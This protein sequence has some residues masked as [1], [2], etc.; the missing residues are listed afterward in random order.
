MT[1]L[2]K[3][4][5]EKHLKLA[6]CVAEK[7]KVTKE[8]KAKMIT[9]QNILFNSNET[10]LM[11][12]PEFLNDCAKKFLIKHL[13]VID[14]L[15]TN[16]KITKTPHLFFGSY[17][18]LMEHLDALIGIEKYYTMKKPLP[19]KF[20][21]DVI[22][23]KSIY[24]DNMIKRYWHEVKTK[25]PAGSFDSVFVREYFQKAADDLMLYKKDFG[26]DQI[27]LINVFYSNIFKKNYGE[28]DEIPDD[29][30]IHEDNFDEVTPDNLEIP[31]I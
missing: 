31:H 2:K 26:N 13:K 11:V 6:L 20:K 15:M 17:E 21:A 18:P 23:N 9:L 19:S 10:Q 27:A 14:T 16:V 4:K 8:E 1:A 3:S 12:S 22:E 28:A 30:K 29:G 7:M 5:K 24:M 25:Q